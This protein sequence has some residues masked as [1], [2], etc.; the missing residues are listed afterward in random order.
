MAGESTPETL[1]RNLHSDIACRILSFSEHTDV[2]S[3]VPSK[4][5]AH[6][7]PQNSSVWRPLQLQ[8]APYHL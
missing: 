1:T 5:S 3:Y 8:L 2:S 6:P 4:R 7:S